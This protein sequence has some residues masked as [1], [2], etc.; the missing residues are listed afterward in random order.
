MINAFEAASNKQVK[1]EIKPCR[2]DD[3]AA[4]YAS[5]DK[6]FNELG[7]KSERGLEEMMADTWALAKQYPKLISELLKE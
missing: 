5:V 2:S 6:S 7:W 1:F 3:I 4:C